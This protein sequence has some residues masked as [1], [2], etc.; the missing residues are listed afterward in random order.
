MVKGLA[1]TIGLNS[2]D[3]QHYVGWSGSLNAAETDAKSMANIAKSKGFQVKT[4]LTK[5]V[6]RG[7]VVAE[8]SSAATELMSGDIFLLCY[9]GHGGQVP[10][11]NHD[12]KKGL[13]DTWCLYDGQLIDDELNNLFSPFPEGVRSLVFSDSCHSGTVTKEAFI[14]G[15]FLP[16]STIDSQ[17][18]RHKFLPRYNATKTYKKN[19]DFYDAILADLERKEVRASVLLISGCQ[20]NQE[21]SDG[22]INSLF[23]A[24]LL[25]VWDNGN[26]NGDYKSFHHEILK[27]MPEQQTPNYFWNGEPSPIFEKQKPFTI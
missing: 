27:L 14:G 7:Q 13:A 9:S 21:A 22:I 1:L 4:L 2:V 26:F 23:T 3:L 19:K 20:D 16:P 17:A 11:V 8:I 15:T 18:A 5:Q 10:D 24:T 12:E 6:T 25:K